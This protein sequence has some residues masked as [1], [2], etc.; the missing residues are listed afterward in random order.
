[1]IYWL[2]HRTAYGYAQTVDLAAHLLHLKPRALPG[3]RVISARLTCLPRPDHH[4]ETHD[5]FGNAATR[6]FLVAPHT[7]FEVTAESLVEVDFAPPPPAAETPPWEQVAAAAQGA[8]TAD[9]IQATR[10][11]P[12]LP[13]ATAYART[14]F[15]PG[16]RVLEGL[17]ELNQRMRQDFVFQAGVTSI[18][19]PIADVLRDRRGV[20]QDF[21]QV[22][23]AAL[24]G[25]G[26]P[27]R[28]VSGYVRTRPPPGQVRRRGADQSHAWVSAWM[29]P[30][31]G[32][33]QLDPTNGIVVR[34]EHVILA[35]GRDFSDIS[36]L[37]GVLL[38]GGD[39]RLS[40]SVDLEPEGEG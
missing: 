24:R 35:W 6:L 27:A 3:Q 23:L 2:R 7:S 37:R 32:W 26:L 11:V 12:L 4:T 15:P 14:S 16:R 28:Y 39:H 33:V 21:T 20:C 30:G 29:G 13:E 40:V 9:F 17:L 19:T 31:F 8:E 5:H 38:G 34:D 25:L 22:M 36:P 18:T 10:H 1:M